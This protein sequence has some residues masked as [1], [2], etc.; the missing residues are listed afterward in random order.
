GKCGSCWAFAAAGAIEG[1]MFN[2]TGKVTPLSVQNLVDCSK[3][4]GNNGCASGNTY[5][6]FQYVLHNGGVEAEATYPY[7]RR[8]WKCRYRPERSAAKIKAFIILPESEDAL[9]D[10][11][12]NKG[13]VAVSIDAFH[14][15]FLFYKSVIIVLL[16]LVSVV[17]VRCPGISHQLPFYFLGIYHEPN[18]SSSVVNHAVL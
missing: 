7:E 17:T 6:A 14:D 11:V 13:P 2:K 4:Q 1:Q 3:P 15:S 5:N 18:C 12:A 10:A 9:M 16:L 8:E